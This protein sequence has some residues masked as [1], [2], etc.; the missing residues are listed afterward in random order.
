MKDFLV[1]RRFDFVRNYIRKMLGR[2]FRCQR[3]GTVIAQVRLLRR[4]KWKR[5]LPAM[6]F[7]R[8]E[9][10]S[11]KAM[12]SAVIEHVDFSSLKVV[13]TFLLKVKTLEVVAMFPSQSEAEQQSGIPRTNI[14]G[15]LL[16]DRPLGGC[17]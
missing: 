17:F 9:T 10:A 16:Q 11:A 1:A 15:G 6:I 12:T 14:S 2:G 7:D 8:S 13:A 4:Q 3:M 5:Y